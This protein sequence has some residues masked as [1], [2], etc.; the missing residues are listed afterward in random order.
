V[1]AVKVNIYSVLKK[2]I[3]FCEPEKEEVGTRIERV[4]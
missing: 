1:D 2:K 4:E 3:Y